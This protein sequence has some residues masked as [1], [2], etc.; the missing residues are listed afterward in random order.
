MAP[1][2]AI[3]SC[4]PED[5]LAGIPG[6]EARWSAPVA[7]AP[8]VPLHS[9]AAGMLPVVQALI[10]RG[11]APAFMMA[12]AALSLLELI[13]LRRALK[14]QLLAVFVSVAAV[15]IIAIGYLFNLVI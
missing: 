5:A 15:G 12:V 8:G 2:A 7:V 13:S 11:A 6:R 3:Y 10:A 4:V 1:G 9:G 14:P